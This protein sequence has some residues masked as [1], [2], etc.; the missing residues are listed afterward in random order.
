MCRYM[1]Q[2]MWIL[3]NLNDEYKQIIFCA[4]FLLNL[5]FP[6]NKIILQMKKM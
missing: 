5:L 1:L 4:I 2:A 6:N 3:G